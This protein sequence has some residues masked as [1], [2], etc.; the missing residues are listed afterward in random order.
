MYVPDEQN[1]IFSNEAASGC[2]SPMM[3]LLVCFH[4]WS[5]LVWETPVIL[6]PFPSILPNV[7]ING[8]Q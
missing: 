4:F 3:P 6:L 2:S 8:N 7:E 1:A 5:I